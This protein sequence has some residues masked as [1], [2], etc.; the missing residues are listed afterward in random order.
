V[1]EKSKFII[2]SENE[3]FNFICL[4]KFCL[5]VQMGIIGIRIKNDPIQVETV[6]MK[7]II[8]IEISQHLFEQRSSLCNAHFLKHISI[9]G[10]LIVIRL[11][12]SYR[13][14]RGN[15]YLK[16]N[17]RV[18]IRIAVRYSG[19]VDAGAATRD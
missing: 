11:T 12:E 9:I 15:P 7:R 5:Y 17:N 13:L 6:A 2:H 3:N 14:H 16:I 8:L 18:P 4:Y 10:L 19:C 1:K